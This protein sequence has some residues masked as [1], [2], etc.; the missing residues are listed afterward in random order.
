MTS[1]Y[2]ESSSAY[3]YLDAVGPEERARLEAVRRYRLVDQPVEE[4][5]LEAHQANAI[6][7]TVSRSRTSSPTSQTRWPAARC[8]WASARVPDQIRSAISSS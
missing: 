3:E 2:P 6:R 7:S 1:N 4:R 8:S 5:G